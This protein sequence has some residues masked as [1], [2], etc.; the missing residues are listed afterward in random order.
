[1]SKLN[2]IAGLLAVSLVSGAV[3]APP[4]LPMTTVIIDSDHGPVMFHAEVAADPQSQERGLMFRTK[5]ASDTGML[6]D[7]HRSAYQTFWMKNT[8][9]P[10]DMIFIRDDGTISSIAPNAVPYSQT[11]I[12][13]AEPVRAVLEINGGQAAQLGIEPDQHV[14]NAVFGNT[15]PGQK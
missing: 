4:A 8:I 12:P 11:P 3:G 14:H 2:C 10:L 13:S 15:L 6:F 5:L 1:M 7:F 9:L